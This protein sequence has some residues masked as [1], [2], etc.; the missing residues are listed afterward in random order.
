MERGITVYSNAKINLSIDV[1]GTLPGGMH[2]VDMV[3][4]QVL[5]HDDVELRYT[6]QP[7]AKGGLTI[8]L[9]PG[10]P[11]LPSDGRN[12][13]FQAAQ[14]MAEQTGRTGQLSIRI[15]KRIPVAAGLAGGSGNAAAV[16]H[17]LNTI[18]GMNQ[19]LGQLCEWGAEL[20]SDVPFCLIGQARSN[21][22][23]PRAVRKDPLATSCA[24]ATG[25]GTTLTRLAPLRTHLVI[26]KP[27]ISV[28]T[29]GVYQGI[30]HCPILCRPDTD[31]LCK[32]LSEANRQEAL[33][34][35]VNVLENYTL[36][37]YPKVANL[38]EA[39]GR[40]IEVEQVLMSGSGPTVFGIFPSKAIA[41]NACQALRKQGYEAY[42]T[43]T[44]T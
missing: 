39:M 29:K 12:L 2:Q 17:G 36:E 33:G 21:Y 35:M 9:S 14:K 32:A 28:S 31:R 20:G 16:F 5:F 11:Y 30:D 18:W 26:A 43:K 3:M 42:S 7:S 22:V 44:T 40:C 24:R 8:H 37:A 10:R 19:S 4:Q 13:A 38:K 25:T 41:Q 34:Q 27:A 15:R 23:L 6:D 1:I